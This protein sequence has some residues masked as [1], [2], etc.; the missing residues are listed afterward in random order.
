MSLINLF[1]F[2]IL[3]SYIFSKN[4]LL[5]ITDSNYKTIVDKSKIPV[6]LIFYDNTCKYCNSTIKIIESF[7]MPSYKEN[8]T[9]FGKINLDENPYLYYQFNV[10]KIPYI[11]ILENNK[12]FI[13]NDSIIS[14]D[15][16]EKFCKEERLYENGIKIPKTISYFDYFFYNIYDFSDNIYDFFNNNFKI[17]IN[18]DY[19]SGL[20]ILLILILFY[21]EIKLFKFLFEKCNNISFNNNKKI[22]KKKH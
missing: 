16:I 3:L 14:K 2:K 17:Q 9:I 21:L 12:M 6:I 15:K 13:Y 10:K 18:K 19:I 20:L 7:I 1:I 4:F 11:I 22:K 8:E 5:E